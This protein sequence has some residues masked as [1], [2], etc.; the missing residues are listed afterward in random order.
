[1]SDWFRDDLMLN[2]GSEKCK[3]LLVVVI[4]EDIFIEVLVEFKVEV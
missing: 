4:F 3:N 2:I 1:M